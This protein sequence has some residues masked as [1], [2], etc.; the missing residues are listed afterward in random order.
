MSYTLSYA[1]KKH[2]GQG[3]EISIPR[4][5]FNAAGKQPAIVRSIR[6]QCKDAGISLPQPTKFDQRTTFNLY[7]NVVREPDV[8]AWKDIVETAVEKALQPL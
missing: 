6:Q 2:G 4:D 7:F 3:L 1:P 8:E 5:V